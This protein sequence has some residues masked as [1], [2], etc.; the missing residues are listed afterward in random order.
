MT[1]RWASSPTLRRPWRAGAGCLKHGIRGPTAA[2]PLVALILAAA[3]GCQRPSSSQRPIQLQLNWR[4]DAQHGGYF[5]A[6]ALGLFADEGLEVEIIQ[7][8]PGTPVIPKLVMGRA[9]FAIVNADQI[10]QAR[11]Q[12]ADIVAVFAP[13][14][15]SPRC[16]MV[17]A[18]AGIRTLEELKDITLAMNEGRTFAQFL[19][20]KLPLTGVK[21]V[22]Y[23]GSVSQFLLNE[24]FA[25]QAYVFSEP[26]L[27]RRRGAQ[28]HCLMVS[29]TGFDPYTSVVAVHG[30]LLRRN[31][32]LVHRFVSACRRGW[33]AYLD[34]PAAA[35]ARIADINPDM[36]QESLAQATP[37]IRRL[38]LPEGTDPTHLGEMSAGRWEQL[39]Q[40]MKSIGALRYATADQ[41]WYSVPHRLEPSSSPALPDP[42]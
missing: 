17:H 42:D 13:L 28:P 9:D 20:K 37:E 2:I 15:H 32:D 18:S 16:I 12:E 8:G 11:E 6:Q 25:Q 35:H 29:Q 22:P 26:L 33:Q 19:K 5:A 23:T 4:A 38:C 24:R 10:L 36:D 39:A 34:S 21:I 41:A 1:H 27:V 30:E 14:Q 31:P 3:S 7:G 40:E